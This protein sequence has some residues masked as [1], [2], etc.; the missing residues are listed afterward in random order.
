MVRNP[1][2]TSQAVPFTSYDKFIPEVT[3]LSCRLYF[4]TLSFFWIMLQATCYILACSIK[5]LTLKRTWRKTQKLWHPCSE[6][7]NTSSEIQKT[8]CRLGVVP[9]SEP[10]VVPKTGLQIL[11]YPLCLAKLVGA[12]HQQWTCLHRKRYWNYRMLSRNLNLLYYKGYAPW[13][14]FFVLWLQSSDKT[15]VRQLRNLPCNAALLYTYV[16]IYIQGAGL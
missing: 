9:N 6:Q 16:H 15:H 11:G 1:P 14:L 8:T 10:K 4:P 13:V 12:A 2:A 7:E 5:R 3:Y